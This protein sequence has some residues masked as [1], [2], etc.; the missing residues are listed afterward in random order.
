MWGPNQQKSPKKTTAFF[1]WCKALTEC[2]QPYLVLYL[3]K[4]LP[5]WTL[6]ASLQWLIQMPHHISSVK[7][8]CILLLLVC[9][10][11]KRTSDLYTYLMSRCG[12]L[13]WRLLRTTCSSC[14]YCAI[15]I[16]QY[17]PWQHLQL[18]RYSLHQRKS[19]R[20]FSQMFCLS[21][22]ILR[23]SSHAIIPKHICKFGTNGIYATLW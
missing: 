21:S 12:A 23:C 11:S 22:G 5:P 8:S 14:D 15:W 18:G 3:P 13:W 10:T 4:L 1:I 6:P 7:L 17:R 20:S 2:L 19:A 16:P 9:Q